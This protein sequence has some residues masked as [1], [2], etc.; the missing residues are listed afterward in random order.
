MAKNLLACRGI[1]KT[2][3][4]YTLPTQMLQ[5]R[6]LRWR[7]HNKKKR[8]HALQD[9]SFQVKR[10]EWLGIYG[11]NGSGKTTLLQI[12]AGI[13]P[14][15]EGEV[16]RRGKI[17]CFFTLGVGF[18]DEKGAKE[19]IYLHGLLHGMAPQDIKEATEKIIRFAEV[20]SHVDLPLKCYSTGMRSR[21]AYAAAAHIDSDVYLFDEVLAVGDERFKEKCLEHMK[22]MKERGKTVVLVVHSEQ[23]L[24]SFCDRI[25]YLEKGR[26]VRMRALGIHYGEVAEAFRAQKIATR[27]HLRKTMRHGSSIAQEAH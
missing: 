24:E 8:I 14:Q 18:H 20:E 12:L 5:D 25:L 16:I 1:S 9:I 4:Q 17:S 22:Q 27:R 2:Y 7:I 6:I 10:G 13:L 19:N 21:L 11:P 15:D 26:K 3:A 23:Q